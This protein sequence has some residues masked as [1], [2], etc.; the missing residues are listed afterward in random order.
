M[1]FTTSF[2]ALWVAVLADVYLTDARF[3]RHGPKWCW[4]IFVVS[5]PIVGA[6]AWMFFGRPYFTVRRDRRAFESVTGPEDTP[7]WTA[8][9]ARGVLPDPANRPD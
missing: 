5:L 2:L 7:E 1:L 9:V 6:V 8:F 4:M 3:V